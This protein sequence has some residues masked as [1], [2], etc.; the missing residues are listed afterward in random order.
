MVI[1]IRIGF[2]KVFKIRQVLEISFLGHIAA[3]NIHLQ[4]ITGEIIK[5]IHFIR[6]KGYL[7]E[8][9]NIRS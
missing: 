4:G 6:I 8:L 2:C 3:V 7:G 5:K 9:L 1:T